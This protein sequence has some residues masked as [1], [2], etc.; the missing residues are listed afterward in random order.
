MIDK[1]KLQELKEKLDF[2][3]LLK[4]TLSD[5]KASFEATNKDLIE[6]IKNGTIAIEELKNNLSEE[7]LKE[8]K[9]TKLKK[10]TGGLGIRETN[11]IDYD[12]VKALEWA[13]EK[14]LFLV[15]DK[16][17]FDKSAPSLGLDF[18]KQTKETMVTFPKEITI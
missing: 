14:D 12:E 16:K 7:G 5:N 2:M 18:V 9:E 15:L 4:S 17:G 10:L 6:S 1:T 13:K 11:K 3:E 8:Y